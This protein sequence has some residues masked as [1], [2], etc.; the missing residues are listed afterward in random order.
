MQER[1]FLL[2]IITVAVA[3]VGLTIA[4]HGCNSGGGGSPSFTLKGA[5]R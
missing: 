1:K 2:R 5:P 3:L 4:I